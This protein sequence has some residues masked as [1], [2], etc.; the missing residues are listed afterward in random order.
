MQEEIDRLIEE[1]TFAWALESEPCSAGARPD[2]EL[3]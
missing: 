3:F 1:G 2:D